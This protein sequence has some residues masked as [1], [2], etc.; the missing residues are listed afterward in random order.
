M[1]WRRRRRMEPTASPLRVAQAAAIPTAPASQHIATTM[2]TSCRTPTTT[3]RIRTGMICPRAAT[4]T[5]ALPP[6]RVRV[7]SPHPH[8][9]TAHALTMCLDTPGTCMTR[10]ATKAFTICFRII[11]NI[12]QRQARCTYGFVGSATWCDATYLTGFSLIGVF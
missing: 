9:R 11:G 3:M 8:I 6:S 10:L 1:E 2:L 12:E 7:P 4:T 5:A